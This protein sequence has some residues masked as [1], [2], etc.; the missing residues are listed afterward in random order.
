MEPLLDDIVTATRAALIKEIADVEAEITALA[1]R[2][3]KGDLVGHEFHGNQW[4]GGQG[5][6][7][8]DPTATRTS[9]VADEPLKAHADSQK[10]EE[11]MRQLVSEYKDQY[12]QKYQSEETRALDGAA[13]RIAED[14]KSSTNDL[15]AAASPWDMMTTCYVAQPT[16]FGGIK[17]VDYPSLDPAGDDQDNRI[18]PTSSEEMAKACDAL[19]M[20][21]DGTS[22]AIMFGAGVTMESL[23]TAVADSRVSVTALDPNASDTELNMNVPTSAVFASNSSAAD[24]YLRTQA[25]T[26]LLSAWA[27]TSNDSN[28]HSLAMQ[29]AAAKEFG[30]KDPLTWG[31]AQ[32]VSDLTLAARDQL[33]SDHGAV[34]QDFLRTQYDQ[35]QKALADQGLKPTDS[36]TLYRGIVDVKLP[37]EGQVYEVAT[38]PLSS[39]ST[40]TATADGFSTDGNIVA[41]Q[42]PVKDILS[43][44]ASGFG[45]WYE[46]EVVVMGGSQTAA[47]T[48]HV[49]S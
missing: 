27:G 47:Q 8:H 46:Q 34:Y 23:Q 20:H 40:T 13:H 26:G 2:A 9:I 28:E 41:A 35:T 44:G 36:V 37:P 16:E 15:V 49:T 19:V 30:I 14:M 3:A 4:T 38:R 22:T 39:W 7:P 12:R 42:V 11:A 48:L 31:K 45:T 17:L 10:V 33:I 24:E 25:T 43:T 29:D 5:A 18:Y 6:T 21:D 1:L 32:G